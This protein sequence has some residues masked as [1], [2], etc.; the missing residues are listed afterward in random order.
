[1]PL[2]NISI[3][4]CGTT[5]QENIVGVPPEVL[6][7]LVKQHGEH[8]ALLEEEIARLADGA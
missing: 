4:I 5:R 1:M 3:N 7:A 6:T 2:R 8:S